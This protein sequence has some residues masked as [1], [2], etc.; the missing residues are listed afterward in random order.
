MNRFEERMG[1]YSGMIDS[2]ARNASY[3]KHPVHSFQ[4]LV[5]EATIVLYRCSQKYDALD[6][7]VF[8]KILSRSIKRRFASIFRTSYSKMDSFTVQ[9]DF[10]ADTKMV[11]DVMGFSRSSDLSEGAYRSAIEEFVKHLSPADR[12]WFICYMQSRYPKDQR[13]KARVMERFRAI[14]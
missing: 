2:M 1:R 7:K 6:E 3:C 4:D 9:M 11:N 10:S 13:G 14:A 5:Q 12:Q 8:C